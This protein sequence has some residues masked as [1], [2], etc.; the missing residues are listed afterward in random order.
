MI[1]VKKMIKSINGSKFKGKKNIYCQ[2]IIPVTPEKSDKSVTAVPAQEEPLMSSSSG[3][4]S[5]IDSSK[6]DDTTSDDKLRDYV[7]C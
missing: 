1:Y 3:M 2:G 4:Q 5:N 6:I 7:F